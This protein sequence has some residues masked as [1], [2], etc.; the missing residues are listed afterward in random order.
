MS[1]EMFQSLLESG[2]AKAIIA[3]VILGILMTI[4]FITDRNRENS[5]TKALTVSAI[6]IA[7]AFILNQI[8]LFRMPRAVR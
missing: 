7:L 5:S 4:F 1:E 8:T 3:L 2:M 6:A